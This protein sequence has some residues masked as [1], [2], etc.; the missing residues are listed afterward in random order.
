MYQS[1]PVFAGLLLA[2]AVAGLAANLVPRALA[3]H[4]W[5]RAQFPDYPPHRKAL[6]P[7]IV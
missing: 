5:Y 7:Y 3:L 6:V 4:R 1:H 2:W